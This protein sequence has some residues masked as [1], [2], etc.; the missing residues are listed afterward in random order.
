MAHTC[1]PNTLGGQHG[2]IIW[3]QEFNTSLGNMAHET[4][5]GLC[6]E[7][8]TSQKRLGANIQLFFFLRWSFAVVTQ[9]GVQWHN[10]GSPQPP[11][12]GF[13]QFSCLS[14]SSSWDYRHPPP[15]LADFCIFIR[16]GVSP[17][18]PHQ[19][20]TP[21]LRWST[22]LSL[23]KCWDYRHKPQCQARILIH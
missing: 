15:Y 12:P 4:N 19:S 8:P 6:S 18:W 9:T 1:N 3:I 7:N 20:R 17:S 13:K 16:D 11:P 10:L 14:L 23:P 5:S 21:D 2:W 22:W